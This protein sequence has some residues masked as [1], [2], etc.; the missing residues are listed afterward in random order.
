MF[1]ANYIFALTFVLLAAPAC[2]QD[3][4]PPA[5][6][7]GGVRPQARNQN[8]SYSSFDGIVVQADPLEIKSV[9]GEVRTFLPSRHEATPEIQ[10]AW[11]FRQTCLS[12]PG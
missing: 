11:I 5:E 8:T 12:F 6:A 2:A 1:N 3:E 9:N 10:A 4:S 7:A